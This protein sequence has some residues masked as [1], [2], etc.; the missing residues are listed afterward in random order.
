M[1]LTVA[2]WNVLHRI[3]AENWGELPA[4]LRMG[5]AERHRAIA[6]RVWS[7]GWSVVCLQEVSG[8]QLAALRLCAPRDA[9]VFEHTY[10]RVPRLR[11]A[12]VVSCLV[13]PTEHLVT[14][15]S[16]GGAHVRAA[17]TFPTDPGKGLLSVLLPSGVVV[18]NTHVTWGAPAAAQLLAVAAEARHTEGMAVVCGDFNA[19]AAEVSAGVGP[20]FNF[21]QP[22]AGSLPTRPRR[23]GRNKYQHIDHVFTRHGLVGALRVWDAEGLSD[24]NLVSATVQSAPAP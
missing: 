23:D 4:L 3:H 9:H 18:V 19:S 7:G 20:E 16:G 21:G 8:D 24:H 17:V 1:Q 2:T 13:K 14:L 22:P 11:A 10:P 12:N 15:V 5:E 6:E